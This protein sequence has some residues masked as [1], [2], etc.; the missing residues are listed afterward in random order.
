MRSLAVFG[1]TM[2][3]LVVLTLVGCKG[4]ES[5]PNIYDRLYIQTFDPKDF[6]DELVGNANT[7]ITLYDSV[8]NLIATENSSPAPPNGGVEETIDY[9]VGLEAGTYYVRIAEASGSDGEY[10]IR[11]LTPAPAA[12]PAAPSFFTDP[13]KLVTNADYEPP[14]DSGNPWSTGVAVPIPIDE[15]GLY[16]V[17]P[18]GDVDHVKI[19]LP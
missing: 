14:D 10:G 2:S 5:D 13:A 3:F 9:T 15:T 11:V 4:T 16:R 19:V 7:S 8:G 12:T 1:I 17:L 6:L 18:S